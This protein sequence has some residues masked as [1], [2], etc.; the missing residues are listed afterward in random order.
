[1][2]N[3]LKKTRSV[4]E[5]LSKRKF[6]GFFLGKLDPKTFLKKAIEVLNNPSKPSPFYRD[7][8]SLGIDGK[9]N[10]NF[11]GK[12]I[13]K[14]EEHLVIKSN[15]EIDAKA[16]LVCVPQENKYAPVLVR[17]GVQLTA[18]GD[19]VLNLFP[20]GKVT[21]KGGYGSKMCLTMKLNQIHLKGVKY[22]SM[23]QVR[24]DL[25]NLLKS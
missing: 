23:T 18:G 4:L 8:S 24:S 7:L 6:A 2:V 3:V 17:Q 1:M 13:G 12:I 20:I 16:S 15:M 21:G 5:D 25:L 14:T 22:F 11:S 10:L 9:F 19:E